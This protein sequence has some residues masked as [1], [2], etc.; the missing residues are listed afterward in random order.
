MF[1]FKK[2]GLNVIDTLMEQQKTNSDLIGDLIGDLM[3]EQQR[4]CEELNKELDNLENDVFDIVQNQQSV[5]RSLQQDLIKLQK[6]E[7]DFKTGA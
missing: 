7:K 3:S 5:I 1:K 6:L 4:L 2:K